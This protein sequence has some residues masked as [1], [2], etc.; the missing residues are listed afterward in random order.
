[1]KRSKG[2]DETFIKPAKKHDHRGSIWLI[3]NGRLLWCYQCGA[4]TYNITAADKRFVGNP[5]G[6]TRGWYRTTGIGGPNPASK[7]KGA[8]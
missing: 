2:Y 5:I 1:M 6:M 3:S 8:A 4:W 7:T